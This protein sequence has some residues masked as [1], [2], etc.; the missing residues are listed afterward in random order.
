MTCEISL[1]S[2]RHKQTTNRALIYFICGNPGLIDF[3]ADFFDFLRG[4]LSS[5]EGSTT[6]DIYGR[7][8]LGFD[9]ADHTPFGARNEPWDLEEQ[10]EGMYDDVAARKTQDRPYDFVILMGHSVGAYIAVEI[11][12][13]HMKQRAT[14]APHLE[15]QHGFLLFPTL[16]DIAL[17]SSGK[18]MASLMRFT[19]FEANAHIC[20]KAILSLI[21]ENAIRWIVKNVMRF[22]AHAAAVVSGWLK[23]RD[24]VWQAIHLGKSELRTICAEKWEDELWEVTE[25]SATTPKFFMF[26][27]RQDHWVA[28]HARDAFIEKRREHGER[29]GRTSIAVDEGDIKHA[30]CVKESKFPEAWG[31]VAAYGYC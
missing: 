11:F 7:N 8:L 28:D 30:F 31:S 9:D 19:L 5:S 6:Y 17:S 16:T 25:R 27:A 29:G 1:P 12:H 3:Y 14:R 26:Y 20:A 18:H 15:L 24:G 23:S 10:I 13:R 21:P 22:N 4:L 2:P